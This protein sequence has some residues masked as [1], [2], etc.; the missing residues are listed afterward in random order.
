MAAR[1]VK[2]QT[3]IVRGEDVNYTLLMGNTFFTSKSILVTGGAQGIGM[4]TSIAFARHGAR[5]FIAD[6]D[7]EAGQELQ[8]T[9]QSDRWEATF[10]AADV[11]K[12]TDVEHLIQTVAG[13]T[14][15]IDVLINNAG[16]GCSKSLADQNP[17]DWERVIGINL[18]G[19]Y[20]CSKM[21]APHMPEGSAIV[22]ISS[23]RALMSEANTEPYSA[24]KGGVLALTHS[25]A[26]SLAPNRIRVNAICPGWIDVSEYQKQSKRT[27][28]SLSEADHL[29]HPV[30]RV[31]C[32]E[33]IAEACLFLAD[34][35]KSGFVTGQHLVVD[36][37]MTVKMIYVE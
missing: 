23:T 37:G 26:M 2:D 35:T 14:G 36:G 10:V 33:D 31:G 25:L 21:A 3:R 6:I 4:A 13:T 22:N 24:S 5:L 16:V 34:T 32:P 30:G 9:L 29:Q 20:L 18:R 12:E 17:V 19:P 11:S 1:A 7:E 27:Q 8:E 15:Q 28:Q